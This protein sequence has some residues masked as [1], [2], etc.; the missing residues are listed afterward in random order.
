[1]PLFLS[2]VEPRKLVVNRFY[3]LQSKQKNDHALSCQQEPG[4]RI[5]VHGWWRSK[6]CIKDYGKDLGGIFVDI[7]LHLSNK[8]TGV[9]QVSQASSSSTI[10]SSLSSSVVPTHIPI[11]IIPNTINGRSKRLLSNNDD[12]SDTGSDRENIIIRW[13][14]DE[15]AA[16]KEAYQK[17]QKEDQKWVKIRSDPEFAHRFHESRTHDSLKFKHKA[18]LTNGKNACI[19]TAVR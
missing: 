14:E 10:G 12:N 6:T 15:I 11:S 13:S 19:R 8:P 3:Y 5:R 16:L 1:M 17:H 18:L 9:N 2:R 7:N 4:V